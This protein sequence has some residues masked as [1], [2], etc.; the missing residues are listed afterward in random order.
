MQSGLIVLTATNFPSTNP[1]RVLDTL[2]VAKEI[3]LG[4]VG[5]LWEIQ[6]FF[7]RRPHW[8]ETF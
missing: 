7:G 4:S 2:P 3:S 8:A 6:W 1:W 5:L